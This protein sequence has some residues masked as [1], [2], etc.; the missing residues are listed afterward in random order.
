[1]KLLSGITPLSAIIYK[2]YAKRKW[3]IAKKKSSRVFFD[4][5][6]DNLK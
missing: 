4:T 2:T 3:N 6:A 1:M 5:Q